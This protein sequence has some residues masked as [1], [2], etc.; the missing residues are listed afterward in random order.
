MNDTTPEAAAMQI[1]IHRRMTEEQ[2]LLLA[3]EMTDMMREATLSRLRA[4]H[5][6]WSEW[7]LKRELI[8]YSFGDRP[9]PSILL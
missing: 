3:C 1:A 5:R 8:R 6:D 7:E 4:E 9:W 2:R